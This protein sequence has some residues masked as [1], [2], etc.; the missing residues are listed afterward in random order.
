MAEPR[1]DEIVHAPH[2]LRIC[3]LLA[4]TTSAEFGVVRDSLGVADSVT[5]KHLK[6]L[7]DA[8]YVRLSKPTGTGGR[9]KTWISL[10]TA[11]RRAF[12]AHLAALQQM[13]AAAQSAEPEPGRRP[14][15]AEVS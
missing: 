8:G 2:R 4:T 14:D 13:A 6:V 10:T 9:A 11:G 15:A 12:T 7:A 1:F 5:S 3:A